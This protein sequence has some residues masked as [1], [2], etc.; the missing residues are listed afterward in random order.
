MNTEETMSKT[1]KVRIAVAVNEKGE[2][3]ASGWRTQRGGDDMANPS[4]NYLSNAAREDVGGSVYWIE[5][6][7]P[8]PETLTIQ[9]KL[10]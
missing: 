1:V 6:E 5:A 8:V 3:V 7:V 4:D 10:S 2:W 9:G